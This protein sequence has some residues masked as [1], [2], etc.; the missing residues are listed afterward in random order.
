MTFAR[1][2][3]RYSELK[4]S[5]GYAENLSAGNATPSVRVLKS[6][7]LSLVRQYAVMI[8]TLQVAQEYG[9][10]MLALLGVIS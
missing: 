4:R 9:S 7:R 1:L 10:R 2:I 8:H 5:S 3:A 6:Q